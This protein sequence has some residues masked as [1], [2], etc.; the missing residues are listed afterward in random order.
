MKIAEQSAC[1]KSILL[2]EHAVVYGQPAIAIPMEDI[3][4]MAWIE[5]NNQRGIEVDALDLNEKIIVE[6]E[7]RHQFSIVINELMQRSDRKKIN[8]T[9]KLTSKIPQS[10]GM[11]SSAATSAAV[12]RCVAEYFGIELTAKEESEIVFRAEKIVHGTPSGID[13]NVIVYE[14]PILFVKEEEPK[15]LELEKDLYIVIGESGVES[16]TMKMVKNI[17]EL[18]NTNPDEFEKK[19]DTIGKLVKKAEQNIEN[20]NIGEIGILM[21]KNQEILREMELSHPE[22]DTII[23]I[24]R[25]AGA[26]G[27]KLT[28]KGGGGNVVAISDSPKTQK[29]IANAIEGAGY[30]VCK[31][32]VG[33][34]L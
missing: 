6:N 19:F 18:V 9:V 4:A 22:L 13:N 10:V 28:G 15:I 32:K 20:G 16:S 7:N 3:R 8:F 29:M 30:G 34:K 26:L 21:N 2:G 27:A 14:K 12:C 1:G 33:A 24:A 25:K 31:T 5:E 17:R 23:E 11:G